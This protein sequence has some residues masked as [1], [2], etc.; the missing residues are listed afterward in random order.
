MG[1]HNPPPGAQTERRGDA[2]P[3]RLLLVRRDAPAPIFSVT[4]S[5]LTMRY[6]AASRLTRIA[7]FSLTLFQASFSSWLFPDIYSPLQN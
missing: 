4:D 7:Y 6:P 3:V 2:G 1:L 5:Y